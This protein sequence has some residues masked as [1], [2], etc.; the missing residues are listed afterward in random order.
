VYNIYR[1]IHKTEK[2]CRCC[3]MALSMLKMLVMGITLAELGVENAAPFLTAS[4]MM[5][6]MMTC[7]HD[8]SEMDSHASAISPGSYLS[9][10]NLTRCTTISRY[11]NSPLRAAT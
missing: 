9:E 11:S 8:P 5:Q 10:I 3:T 6:I 1:T 2:I 7:R 4:N